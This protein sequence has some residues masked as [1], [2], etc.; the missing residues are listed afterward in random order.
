MS[1]VAVVYLSGTGNTQAMAE[2]I[3][4]AIGAPLFTP[5]EFTPDMVKEYDAIA[6][7]CADMGAEE[8]EDGEFAPMFE[9]CKGELGGKKLG[10][11]GSYGWGGEWLDTW[12]EDCEAAGATVVDTVKCLEA[13]DADALAAC[14]ALAKALAE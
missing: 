1:K 9:A 13:P 14:E 2:A 3:A 10:L 8:L 7:G 6:F 5:A 12:K 4:A 11:F